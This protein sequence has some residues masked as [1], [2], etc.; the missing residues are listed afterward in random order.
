MA[1]NAL[2]HFL[3]TIEGLDV[4]L[5]PLIKR[6]KINLLL[7]LYVCRDVTDITKAQS[8]I[9]RLC[10]NAVKAYFFASNVLNNFVR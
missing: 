5:I 8:W 7:L 9:F 4:K 1:S 3:K 10:Q 6:R 2:L